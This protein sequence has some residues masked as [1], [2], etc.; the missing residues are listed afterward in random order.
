MIFFW[1][2]DTEEE[3]EEEREVVTGERERERE[4]DYFSSSDGFC[5]SLF[6]LKKE[7]E[8]EEKI[9]EKNCHYFFHAWMCIGHLP[10]KLVVE[11]YDLR[12]SSHLPS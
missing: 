5:F 8:E 10:S 2:L 9:D 12:I 3:N 4:R 7:E 11:K 6:N 1:Q